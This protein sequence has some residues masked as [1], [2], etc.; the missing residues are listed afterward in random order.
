MVLLI[1]KAILPFITKWPDYCRYIHF[2]LSEDEILKCP[3]FKCHYKIQILTSVIHR[4]DT[5]SSTYFETD[6]IKNIIY[7]PNFLVNKIESNTQLHLHPNNIWTVSR[8]IK[9]KI[10]CNNYAPATM[11]G[12]FLINK[13]LQVPVDQ[14]PTNRYESKPP[15]GF[16]LFIF[17]ESGTTASFKIRLRKKRNK[18]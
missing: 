3:T 1:G 13:S 12:S 16:P 6:E 10:T 18:N 9:T 8:K 5:K 11:E 2:L 17:P 4:N 14:Q 7:S 15:F